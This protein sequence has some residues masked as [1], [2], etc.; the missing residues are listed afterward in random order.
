MTVWVS[1]LVSLLAG[2][3]VGFQGWRGEKVIKHYMGLYGMGTY[4]VSLCISIFQFVLF[5]CILQ[6]GAYTLLHGAPLHSLLLVLLCFELS[7][8]LFLS[9]V[10]VLLYASHGAYTRVGTTRYTASSLLLFLLCYHSPPACF[11]VLCFV[12]HIVLP[13]FLSCRALISYVTSLIFVMAFI[14]A[15]VTLYVC[16]KS[17]TEHFFFALFV[18]CCHTLR[19]FFLEGSSSSMYKSS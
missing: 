3:Q 11:V 17:L 16:P 14:V 2:G 12:T 15:L 9:R 5:V 1:L 10:V 18:S 13:I 7:T 4:L 19:S 6:E 8:S